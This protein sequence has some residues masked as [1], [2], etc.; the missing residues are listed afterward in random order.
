MTNQS[1]EDDDQATGLPD[2]PKL[3]FLD[4]NIV[5]N[6]HSFGE[7][8]FERVSTPDLEK[9]L[10]TLGPRV[11]A[12]IYAL[13]DFMALG[14]RAGW[15]LAVSPGTLREFAAMQDPNKRGALT[16][17]DQRLAAYFA[18]N[19][20]QSQGETEGTSYSEMTHFTFLQRS[21]MAAL[22]QAFPD[23]QDQQ[24][25]IDA[26]ERGCDIFLTMDYK[27]IWQHR[28]KVRQFGL[29][30]MRPVELLDY[31]RPWAGLLA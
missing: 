6:L 26:V 8:I 19:F 31:V 25:F 12:D 18:E 10:S 24:L 3:I 23:K 7:F 17:W 29:Q 2:L 1:R 14:I 30:A 13:A 11:T 16:A 4:T 15:P 22:L 5:Q 27:T 28:D 20:D 21:S 9:K